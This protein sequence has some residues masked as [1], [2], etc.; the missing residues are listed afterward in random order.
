MV[1]LGAAMNKIR[2]VRIIL[3]NNL[4]HACC[5]AY[6]GIRGAV[7]SSRKLGDSYVFRERMR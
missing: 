2:L 3:I 5:K 6:S 7:I 4:V 1:R